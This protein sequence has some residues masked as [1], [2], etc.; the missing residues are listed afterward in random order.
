MNVIV[1]VVIDRYVADYNIVIM[2]VF[3]CD[4]ILLDITDNIYYLYD[5]TNGL[6]GICK[7]N[8]ILYI[9]Y[10]NIILIDYYYYYYHYLNGF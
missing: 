5:N 1:V 7:L 8:R 6:Y 3:V 2:I 9:Q 10:Q 4:N